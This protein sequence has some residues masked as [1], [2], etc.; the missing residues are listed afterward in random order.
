IEG[1]GS[2]EEPH[3]I[4]EAWI[5]RQVPQCGYC[6]PGMQMSAAAFLKANP[7]PTDDDIDRGI[8]NICRCGCYERIREAIHD[9]AGAAGTGGE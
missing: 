1:L 4:Q 9:A 6:Q 7:E 8:T 2:P 3:P 5:A